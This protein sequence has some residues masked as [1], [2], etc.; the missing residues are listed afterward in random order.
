METI[1]A[2]LFARFPLSRAGSCRIT[3]IIALPSVPQPFIVRRLVQ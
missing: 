3:T 1:K 2:N